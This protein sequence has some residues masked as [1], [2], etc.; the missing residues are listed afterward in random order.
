MDRTLPRH[1]F[2]WLLLCVGIAAIL[3]ST[4]GCDCG[5]NVKPEIPGVEI[6][7]PV[8]A[9]QPDPGGPETP[10]NADQG[11]IKCNTR[12]DCPQ[13]QECKEGTCI[14]TT[15]PVYCCD[16]ENCPQGLA[17]E[18]S[19]GDPGTC[20]LRTRCNHLCDCDQGLACK[21]GFCTVTKE[22][23]YC[24]EKVGCPPGSTCTSQRGG[25]QTCGGEGFTC[26][27]ACDCLPSLG[28]IN[29][30][31]TQGSDP[32]YCC[33]SNKCPKGSKCET[34]KGDK[35]TCG[36]TS[37]CKTAC[38]CPSGQACNN[39]QCVSSPVP[40]Y[41]CDQKENCPSG[42]ACQWK[43][44]RDDKCPVVST[45]KENCDCSQGQYCRGG[46]CIV[47]PSPVYC[48]AK[49]GCPAKASC[50]KQ[51]G[52]IGTCPDKKCTNDTE[53]GK[54]RCSQSGATCTEAV[55]RCRPDGTC[56]NEVKSTRGTCDVTSGRCKVTAECRTHCDC[57]QKQACI[58][59]RCLASGPRPFYCCSKPGCPEKETCFTP[60]GRTS[61]C[62]PAQACKINTDCGK[63]ACRQSGND[64]SQ[65]VPI[66]NAA[67]QCS[68]TS[69]FV[70]NATCQA[71]VCVPKPPQC[72]THCDCPQTL[73]C[74]GGQCVKWSTPVYCCTKAGC[75]SAALC[76]QSN[77]ST[78]KCPVKPQCTTSLQCP[79]SS[80]KTVGADC[81][82]LKYTCSKGK[83]VVS[84][85]LFKGQK[86]NPKTNICETST[87][88]KCRYICDCPQGQGCYK[89]N[90]IKASFPIYCCVK[91]GC[92]S[93]KTCYTRTNGKSTCPSTPVC[94]QDS[95]CGNPTCK[96]SGSTCT[97]STPRCD[98]RTGVCATAGSSIVG[99]CNSAT[100]RCDQAVRCT[101]NCDCPQGL[102]CSPGP[103]GGTCRKGPTPVYCCDKPG[104]PSKAKCIDKNNRG[105]VCPLVCKTPCDCAAGQDCVNT[106]CITGTKPI[107]CCDNKQQCPAGAACKDKT[108]KAGTCPNQTRKCSSPCDCVQGE[109]CVN[110]VCAKTSTPTYCCSNGACPAGKACV[111]KN[112][113][114]G[115][116]KIP[117][118]EVCDC[119][120]GQYC[121]QGFCLE[122]PGAP[123]YCCDKPGC[124]S[125]N[126]CYK[127]GGGF[128]RCPV[129]SCKSPCDCTQGY[130]CRNGK[131]QRV[132]PAVYCCSKTGCP[133]GQACKTTSNQWKTCP[134][135]GGCKSPCDCPQGQDCHKGL[136][137]RVFPA[138]YCC[139]K[140]GC[141]GGQL[142]FDANNKQGK[143]PGVQCKTAC[144]CPRQGQSCVKGACVF[145]SPPTYCC[146]KTGCRAGY[147]CED[148]NGK[149]SY[150]PGTLCKTACD[151]TQQGQSCVRG[152]CTYTS[153]PTYCC[154]K[155]GCRVGSSC[156]DKNGKTS[157][158]PGTQKCKTP[159]DCPQ[160]YDC[161]GGTCTRVSPPVYCCSK[162]GCRRGQ[163]CYTSTGS[164]KACPGTPTCKTACDCQQ[165][166][167][168]QN[169]YCVYGPAPVYCCGKSGCRP[170]QACVNSNG[171]A[172][173][174]AV[175]CKTHCDCNQGHMCSGGT[176]YRRPG[177]Y[178]CD[179]AGCQS[180]NVCVDK[181]GLYSSCGAKPGQT[182]KTRCDCPQGEECV[183]GKCTRRVSPAY[184]CDKP[185]CPSR[186]FCLKKDGK[187][188]ICSGA[189]PFP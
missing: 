125:G 84:S 123:V 63:P 147:Q 167:D 178:C 181:N 14:V 67:G 106:K 20:G 114:K 118:K 18:K 124:A 98:P 153:P 55:P 1:F 179:K 45:C 53:C 120:Q 42:Q 151:C 156:E 88:G 95:D 19:N 39:G 73:A 158:C 144:D 91:P 102:Y 182:C 48:C 25:Q 41:C 107:Y 79:K 78:G 40:V 21:G 85:I 9:S 142:C 163:A 164:V 90:C 101:R 176:C 168:C 28:C 126:G 70:N 54:P 60:D 183:S 127:K 155:P 12:C 6:T 93:N 133:G 35:S 46:Q 65:I 103:L 171:T 76:Y 172:S 112:G 38:D 139:S 152:R 116:C 131:C 11:P 138:V 34:K 157:T 150:C 140:T 105:G 137:V 173:T 58:Q 69:K 13:G 72:K 27:T 99:T 33:S 66:C 26:N 187:S 52:G 185:G 154:S 169:G 8:D 30:Q 82:Q 23:A 177:F 108:G 122:R 10:D 77:G 59:G 2:H 5:S 146:S 92:P 89:G 56:S 80:C 47:G 97:Q 22:K 136:C 165:G 159:C 37:T 75:P 148:K 104:C 175:Q 113:L 68:S 161:R 3:I 145:T 143:C 149:L 50:Y 141:P 132:F 117:C 134:T 186:Y 64:C 32:V 61:T 160:G 121:S 74:R 83:C 36:S 15:E 31:C 57:P 44:G 130:D 170:G 110:G 162:S 81:N 135:S 24:C 174:C 7:N 87:P 16:K 96:Q 166:L 129:S 188:G 109:G 49:P 4:G 189:T 43:D 51:G 111:D 29:G 71:G 94:K 100:G 184:C 180:G 119:P 128:G 86:C 115:K 17:C 62:K